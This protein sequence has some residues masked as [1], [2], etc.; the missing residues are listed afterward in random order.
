MTFRHT[1]AVLLTACVAAASGCATSAEEQRKAQVHQYRSDQAA[2]NGQFG[3]AGEEQGKAADAHHDA[4][5]KAISEGQ[6]IPPQTQR[7]DPY[8]DAG[9]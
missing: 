8:P 7:G 2:E 9:R 4:V 1:V 6:P 3:L 5:K